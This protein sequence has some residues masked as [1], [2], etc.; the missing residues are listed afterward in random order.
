M[1]QSIHLLCPAVVTVGT[2]HH[3]LLAKYQLDP[4][5][6][7]MDIYLDDEC[8]EPSHSLREVAF[9]YAFP[10]RK[11]RMCLVFTFA[12]AC[13]AWWG[14]PMPRLERPEQKESVP[15]GW[16]HARHR[17][18]SSSPEETLWNHARDSRVRW[19]SGEHFDLVHSTQ[20]SAKRSSL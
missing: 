7:I 17:R 3:L 16:S 18:N 9:L 12:E 2:L 15:N 1:K 20:S 8:L 19:K 14:R 5:R 10:A 6:Q 4:V 13:F 11:Q